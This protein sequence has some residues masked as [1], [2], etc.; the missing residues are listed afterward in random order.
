MKRKKTKAIAQ[1]VES[2]L[3]LPIG[4][5]GGSTRMELTDDRRVVVEGCQGILEYEEDIIRLHTTCGTVRFCGSGLQLSG[6]STGGALITGKLL[7]VE[8]MGHHE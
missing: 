1:R 8:F 6:M 5:L 2:L 7:S 3:E 4:A